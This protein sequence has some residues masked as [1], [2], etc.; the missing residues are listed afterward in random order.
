[1]VALV[2]LIMELHLIGWF[3]LPIHSYQKMTAG[4]SWFGAFGAGFLLSIAITP[5]GTPILASVLSYVAYKRSLFVGGTLLFAYGI[6][7]GA[8]AAIV[9]TTAGRLLAKM[10]NAGY[11]DWAEQLA[12]AALM[13]LGLWLLWE[14]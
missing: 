11:Q 12:G 10:K 14:A 5:C 1:M 4:R 9:A 3:R 6:G 8:P 7:F 2:P 13:G